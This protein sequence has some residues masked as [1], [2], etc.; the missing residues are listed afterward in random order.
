MKNIVETAIDAR[1]F[2]ILITAVQA[3]ELIDTLSSSGPFT[4]LLQM[5]TRF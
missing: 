5:M 4:A 2:K 3:A 1:S